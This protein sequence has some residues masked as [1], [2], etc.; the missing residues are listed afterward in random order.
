[1]SVEVEQV[2]I[3]YVANNPGTSVKDV[4]LVDVFHAAAGGNAITVEQRLSRTL[5]Q[6]YKDGKL[7]RKRVSLG[8]GYD[9][10]KWVYTYNT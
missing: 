4:V 3:N 9:G 2:V 7:S 8:P 1:M 6:L 5:A 10:T